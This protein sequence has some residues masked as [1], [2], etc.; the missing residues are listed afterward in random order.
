MPHKSF[1]GQMMNSLEFNLGNLHQVFHAPVLANIPTNSYL[2][3][4]PQKSSDGQMT[5]SSLEAFCALFLLH[6]PG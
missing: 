2:E 1:D 6:F 5:N 4:I 3:Y